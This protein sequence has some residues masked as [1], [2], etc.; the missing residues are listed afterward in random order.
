[1]LRKG[2][3]LCCVAGDMVLNKTGIH[4]VMISLKRS[5]SSPSK[6]PMGGMTPRVGFW[7]LSREQI[8]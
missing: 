5:K 7:R 3:G 4:D 6:E 1:M 2:Q 8:A